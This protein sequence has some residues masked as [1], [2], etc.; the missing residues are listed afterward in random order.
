MYKVELRNPFGSTGLVTNRDGNAVENQQYYAYGR[1]RGGG[2]L[3]TDFTYTG[4]KVDD[5]GLMYYRA[6]YYDPV[7]GQFVSPDTIVPDA[8]SALDYNR[9]MMVRGNPLKYNDPTGHFV[10]LGQRKN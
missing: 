5:T 6:R 10:N 1:P 4:Q 9:Y 8:T 7:I 3:P 2:A